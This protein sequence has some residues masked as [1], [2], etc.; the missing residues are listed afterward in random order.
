MT[1]DQ[2]LL[3]RIKATFPNLFY[4]TCLTLEQQREF[5]VWEDETGR[6][7]IATETAPAGLTIHNRHQHPIHL[8]AID[9]CLFDNQN[10]QERCDGLLFDY[11]CLCFVELKLNVSS[12]KRATPA[13]N[14]ARKQLK[15]SI[16]FFK[17]LFNDLWEEVILEAYIVMESHVYPRAR[18]QRLEIFVSFQEETGVSLFEQ[19][20]KIFIEPYEPG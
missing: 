15:Q 10:P 14:E 1:K 12:W 2:Q 4:T 16:Y 13:G 9:N 17:E 7:T 18:A 3:N 19:N 5:V 11:F 8:V 20:K 6:I